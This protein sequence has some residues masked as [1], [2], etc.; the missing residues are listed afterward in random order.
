MRC[1]AQKSFALRAT[2][3]HLDELAAIVT[4]T[5]QNL[6]EA[7]GSVQRIDVVEFTCGLQVI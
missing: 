5:R 1:A 3:Q 6:A 2:D 4:R 7:A